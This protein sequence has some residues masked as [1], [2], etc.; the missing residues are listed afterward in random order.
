LEIAGRLISNGFANS[1]TEA[2]PLASCDK[3]A[4]RV[5][6]AKAA[7]VALKESTSVMFHQKVN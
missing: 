7:N 5:G 6:S 4:R 1:L 2:E 3:I